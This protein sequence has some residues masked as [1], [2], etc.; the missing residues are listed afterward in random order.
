MT[1]YKRGWGETGWKEMVRPQV[2]TSYVNGHPSGWWSR[3]CNVLYLINPAFHP[4]RHFC[5]S[6]ARS[7]TPRTPRCVEGPAKHLTDNELKMM[8][9]LNCYI[10]VS[11]ML[12]QRNICYLQQWG[13]RC[14]WTTLRSSNLRRSN[15]AHFCRCTPRVCQWSPAEISKVLL[16]VW[17]YNGTNNA[18]L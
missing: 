4:T 3:S 12:E 6:W 1:T 9:C 2:N 10:S 16:E 17:Y 13:R 11:F 18:F 8:S 7:E 15:G 14:R 5:W